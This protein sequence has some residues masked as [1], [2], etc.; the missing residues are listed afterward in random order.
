MRPSSAYSRHLDAEEVLALARHRHE[1][2]LG[3][4]QRLDGAVGA[5]LGEDA[6]ELA[7]RGDGVGGRLLRVARRPVADHLDDLELHAVGLDDA[8]EAVMRSWSAEKPG[9]AADLEQLA[10][11]ADV[12]DQPLAALARP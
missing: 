8:A 7:V 2:M 3:I 10:L 11:L 6:V 12:V 4:D 9:D 5:A 1:G